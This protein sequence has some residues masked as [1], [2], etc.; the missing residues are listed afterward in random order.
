MY[1]VIEKFADL[2]D[3]NHVYEVGD[4]FPREGVLVN[5]TRI[6]ELAGDRNKLGKPLI[7]EEV[8]AK[9]AVP[10]AE[11]AQKPSKKRSAKK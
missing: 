7:I 11:T 3:D 1:K 4:Q 8:E 10:E 6:N 9:E 2:Q 5:Q